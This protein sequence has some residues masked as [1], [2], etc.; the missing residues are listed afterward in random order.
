MNSPTNS[1][2]VA[3]EPF[4]LMATNEL[5]SVFQQLIRTNASGNNQAV[6]SLNNLEY[7]LKFS[8]IMAKNIRIIGIQS[9]IISTLHLV[10]SRTKFLPLA[11]LAAMK[12]NNLILTQI[13]GQQKF[14]FRSALSKYIFGLNL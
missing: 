8:V 9:T 2:L 13:H 10:I 11:D 12:L 3:V 1:Q 5:C 7:K 4:Y 6:L 14:H